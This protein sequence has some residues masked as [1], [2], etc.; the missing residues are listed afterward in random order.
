VYTFWNTSLRSSFIDA[1]IS[2]RDELFFE[3]VY[4]W[5][6]LVDFTQ[7][8]QVSLMKIFCDG[9]AILRRSF[10]FEF[11]FERIPSWIPMTD[12]LICSDHSLP[13][14][15]KQTHPCPPGTKS[16]WHVLLLLLFICLFVCFSLGITSLCKVE[17]YLRQRTRPSREST[18]MRS[19]AHFLP[20]DQ[21][22]TFSCYNPPSIWFIP[23]LLGGR[24]GEDVC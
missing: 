15:P 7:Y 6:C 10:Y 14:T 20:L 2:L 21:R 17:G 13:L 12:V 5:L 24:C 23:G 8:K 16:N 9:K 22:R 18:Y 3:A 1:L 19:H 4:M 11:P